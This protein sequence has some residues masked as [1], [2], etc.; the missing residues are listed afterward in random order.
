[1]E[2]NAYTSAERDASH[3]ELSAEELALGAKFGNSLLRFWSTHCERASAFEARAVRGGVVLLLRGVAVSD[4]R[5]VGS[6]LGS[7]RW[8]CTRV[9]F[10]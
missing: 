4:A 9:L 7:W 3:L 1:M 5:E 8:E 6:E 2:C 10:E